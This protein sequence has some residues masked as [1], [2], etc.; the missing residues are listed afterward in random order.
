M[1]A[2]HP[3]SVCW[4]AAVGPRAGSWATGS[5][6]PQLFSLQLDFNPGLPTQRPCTPSPC[7]LPH[8][9][10]PPHAGPWGRAGS[11]PGLLQLPQLL[12]ALMAQGRRA[13][14]WLRLLS[15]PGRHLPSCSHSG[16]LWCPPCLS[17][18]H[19]QVRMRGA[20]CCCSTVQGTEH[21]STHE[22]QRGLWV[23]MLVK[24]LLCPSP[25]A[26]P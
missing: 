16:R 17:F 1:T 21:T 19:C 2:A 23:L 26:G 13:G 7:P 15:L 18:S 14:W 11:C 20:P 4:R 5:P 24:T 25:S 8:A 22:L 12:S 10:P 6:L 3:P 9:A